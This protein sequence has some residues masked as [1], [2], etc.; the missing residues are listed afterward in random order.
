MVREDVYEKVTFDLRSK[1]CE[2]IKRGRFGFSF[3]EAERRANLESLR[4]LRWRG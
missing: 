3:A 4:K 2:E 1:C